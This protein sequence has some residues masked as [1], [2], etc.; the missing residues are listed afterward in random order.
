MLHA[1]VRYLRAGLIDHWTR[2]A[3]SGVAELTEAYKGLMESGDWIYAGHCLIVRLWRRVAVGDPLPEILAENR[4]FIELLETKKDPDSLQH[5][6]VRA[7]DDA[8]AHGRR[9]AASVPLPKHDGQ[10][11][12]APTCSWPRSSGTT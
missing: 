6:P 4:R 9:G 12:A 1:R 10:H 11:G 8:G 3:R 2:S 7:P 5:V